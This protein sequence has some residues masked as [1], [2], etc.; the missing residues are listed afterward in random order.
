MKQVLQNLK[1]GE[2]SIE[3][4]PVPMLHAQSIIIQTQ[5]T[6]VSSGTE[7]MLV[8]FGR[9]NIVGKIKKQPDKVK[10]VLDKI[11]SDGLLAT[12]ESVQSK[13]D[14]PIPLGYCNVGRVIETG[15]G[16]QDF[17]IG[18]RAKGH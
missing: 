1:T 18:D 5:K 11:K 3:D 14:Q 4:I 7:K 15:S 16:V 8:D 2:T 17:K 10:M 13:L 12:Y 6:L 9:A